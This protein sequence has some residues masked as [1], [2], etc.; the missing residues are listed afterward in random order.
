MNQRTLEVENDVEGLSHN[1]AVLN[2]RKWRR[3]IEVLEVSNL[4]EAHYMSRL[5]TKNYN[6][7]S[8][9]SLRHFMIKVFCAI[10]ITAPL[11]DN[12]SNKKLRLNSANIEFNQALSQLSTK[13]ASF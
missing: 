10:L 2:W 9:G 1:G 3:L 6:P 4:V 8:T 13:Y 7:R 5:Y 11:Y 12:N